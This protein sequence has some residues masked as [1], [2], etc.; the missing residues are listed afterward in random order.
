MSSK[1]FLGMLSVEEC[2]EC[3]SC[4]G[5]DQCYALKDCKR[6]IQSHLTTYH[7]SNDKLE[8][9]ELILA[10]AGLFDLKDEQVENMYVC[11]RHREN[12]GRGWK[13]SKT[14][15]Q[16]PG[17]PSG[18]KSKKVEGRRATTYNIA[19]ETFTIYRQVVPLGSRKYT[20]IN[21]LS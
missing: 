3:G 17:H 14:A 5:D 15:C 7:L 6:D 4:R 1:C 13:K 8:E 9:Y 20:R 2:G 11:A 21:N 16:Y 12:L 10:R 18:A 19:K